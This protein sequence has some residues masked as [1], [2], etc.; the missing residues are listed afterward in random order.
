MLSA[1]TTLERLSEWYLRHC[2]GDWE[3]GFGF[4]ISTL[5]NPGASIKID[6]EDTELHKIPFEEIKQ[7]RDSEDH[8][9]VCRRTETVF[10]AYGAATRFEDMLKIF[11]DWADAH[12]TI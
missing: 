2:N 5:D 8:W 3:H 7:D 6:L 10:E 11:L 1:S 12:R 4:S 9:L